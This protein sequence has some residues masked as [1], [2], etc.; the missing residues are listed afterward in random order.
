ME[1]GAAF[2]T[3]AF[4]DLFNTRGIRAAIETISN[5]EFPAIFGG[6]ENKPEYKSLKDFLNKIKENSHYCGDGMINF[7]Q[8]YSMQYHKSYLSRLAMENPIAYVSETKSVLN[9]ILSILFGCPPEG[10]FGVYEGIS[11][12]K[13][14]YYKNRRFKKG[15]I[16][17]TLA[18]IGVVEDHVKGTLHFHLI[19]FGSISPYVLQ[20]LSNVQ[21]ICNKVATALDYFYTAKYST[22]TNFRNIVTRKLQKLSA[23]NKHV[24]PEK[25]SP[26]VLLQRSDPL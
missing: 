22:Q 18:F 14:R 23:I 17:N 1:N 5:E 15:I 25:L 16:G 4:D 19:F 21:H 12:R 3:L 8:S 9:H 24:K 10:F 26:S 13:T 20:E 6:K 11:S 2:I 7:D